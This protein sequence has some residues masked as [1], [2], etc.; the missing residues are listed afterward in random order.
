MNQKGSKNRR[1]ERLGQTFV[2][3][4]DRYEYDKQLDIYETNPIYLDDLF[5]YEKYEKD[6]TYYEPCWGI[7]K[8]LYNKLKVDGYDVYGSDIIDGVDFLE[9]KDKYDY[10]ITNPPFNLNLEFINKSFEVANKKISFLV[11][12]NYLDTM[13]RYEVFHNPDFLCKNVLVYSKRISFI[14][15]GGIP[16]KCITGMS[17]CWITWEKGYVGET[18]IKWIKN[19]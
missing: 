16:E 11:P 17:F 2:G 1:V 10:I 18:T 7:N 14:K 19:F 15:G 13:K 4:Q 5:K 12:L 6:G 3:R 9:C 8:Y